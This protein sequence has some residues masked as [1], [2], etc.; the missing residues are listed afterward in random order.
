MRA[1]VVYEDGSLDQI[2]LEEDYPEPELEEGW[3]RLD[4]R[5]D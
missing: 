2:V 1:A 4:E 5:N 3:V